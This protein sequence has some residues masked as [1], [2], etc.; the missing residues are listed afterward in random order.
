LIASDDV[1]FAWAIAK[2]LLIVIVSFGTLVYAAWAVTWQKPRQ[3]AAHVG[4]PKDSA[5]KYKSSVKVG[6]VL[7]IAC[8]TAEAEAARHISARTSAD[9]IAVHEPGQPSAAA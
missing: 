9:E 8:G 4:F 5:L 2:A 3:N 7:L 1:V 6:K